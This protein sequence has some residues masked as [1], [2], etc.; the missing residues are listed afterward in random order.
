MTEHDYWSLTGGLVHEDDRGPMKG[1]PF[2]NLPRDNDSDNMAAVLMW[3]YQLRG[4]KPL[5]IDDID[6][7]SDEDRQMLVNCANELQRIEL[8]V[9]IAVFS[10]KE[11]YDSW[12]NKYLGDNEMPEHWYTEMRIPLNNGPT[13]FEDQLLFLGNVS[14]LEEGFEKAKAFLNLQEKEE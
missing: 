2:Y 5:K 13:M 12:R 4:P 11:Q 8:R 7:E 10:S 6:W 1:G 3:N 9:P 14:S